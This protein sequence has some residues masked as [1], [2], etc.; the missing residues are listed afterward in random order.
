MNAEQILEREFLG[1]RARILE[2][3]ACFDRL[4]RAEGRLIESEKW[5]MIRRGIEVLITEKKERPRT[6]QV[7][8]LFS[9]EYNCNWADELDI[10]SRA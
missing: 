4:D 1:M 10:Q 5:K 3:A 8:L 6:E 9:R 2:L 7:Q